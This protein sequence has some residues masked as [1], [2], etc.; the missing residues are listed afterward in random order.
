M[1]SSTRVA[2]IACTEILLVNK[3][4]TPVENEES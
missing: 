4:V 1:N 2:K 3:T